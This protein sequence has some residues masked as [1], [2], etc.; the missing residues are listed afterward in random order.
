MKIFYISF[1][2]NF[3]LFRIYSGHQSI[4]LPPSELENNPEVFLQ[5]LSQH[6]CRDVF[7]NYNV[8]KI[9]VDQLAPQVP[10]LKV[11]CFLF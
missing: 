8:M 9:C 10:H 3:I 11:C 4:L 7:I 5:M 2:N 1:N 6:K